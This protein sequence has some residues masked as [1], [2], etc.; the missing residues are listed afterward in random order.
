VNDRAGTFQVD[1]HAEIVAA[2]A[3][4]RHLQTRIPDTTILH[5]DS[6]IGCDLTGKDA[7]IKTLA[8]SYWDDAP[9]STPKAPENRESRGLKGGRMGRNWRRLFAPSIAGVLL[10]AAGVARADKITLRLADGLPSG[11]IIDRLVI[12]PFIKAVSEASGGTIEIRHFPAEQLGKSRDLLMLTKAGVADIGFIVPSYMSDRMP[13]TTV[14]ELPGIFQTTCQG[15]AALRALTRDGGFLEREEFTPNDIKPLIIFLMPA[16]QLVLSSQHP[17][18]RIADVHGLKIRTPGGAMDLTVMG[19]GAVPI[20]VAP[21]DIYESMSRG[22]LDGALLSYQSVTSYHLSSL[23]K[24]GTTGQDFGTVTITF[25]ISL[26]KWNSLPQDARAILAKAGETLSEQACGPFDKA[27][28]ASRDAIQGGGVK[29]A[30][31]NDSDRDELQATFE[32]IRKDWAARLDR[33]GK[34]GSAAVAAFTDAATV[35][36]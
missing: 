27:E 4:C 36:Q 23:L 26:D 15:N 34:P 20:R 30:P 16:Y 2:E 7:L 29:L 17:L 5:L 6:P 31:P 3:N 9:V 10:A 11:H 8:L 19:M 35:A 28:Q 1:P 12:E 24:A 13:L 32:T 22:T 14:T 25:S 33:R 21:P 18:E